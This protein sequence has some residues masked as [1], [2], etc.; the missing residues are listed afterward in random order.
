MRRWS[1]A[2]CPLLLAS[3]CALGGHAGRSRSVASDSAVT[4]PVVARAPIVQAAWPGD[5]V[6]AVKGSAVKLDAFE[7]LLVQAGVES[8]DQLPPRERPLDREGA[9]RLLALLVEKPLPLRSF[10]QRMG[11]CFLLREVLGSGP[12]SRDELNRR[13]DRFRQVAVLRP[14]GYL[15]WVLSGRT[16]QRAGQVEL[17]DGAF[18][19]DRFVLGQFY[20]GRRGAYRPVDA[21]L[22]PLWDSTILGEVYDDSDV[23]GRAMDG[24]E[25]AFFALA[26]AV[27]KFLS[28]PL[29]GIAELRNLPA[30]V[31]ALIASSPEYLE[32]FK[33]M[34]AGEQIQ[35]VSRLTTT[36]LT[37][38]AGGGAV[39]ASLTRGLGGMEVTGLALSTQGTLVLGRVVVP[40]GEVATVLAVGASVPIVLHSTAVQGQ[41][42][43]GNMPILL[44]EGGPKT[45]TRG[46]PDGA[47]TWGKPETL[48]DHFARHGADFGARTAQEYA[49]MASAFLRRSQAERLPTKIDAQGVIRVYDPKTNTFGAYNPGGTTRTF[50]KPGPATHGYPT[51]LDYW[52]AQPGGKP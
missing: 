29:D 3:G 27:G 15:A 28:R 23:F 42:S 1:A 50:Y 33:L 31:A 39:S 12:A 46:V 13:V 19:A 2:L 20:S 30:G 18:R 14:D 47:S 21:Q 22:Q 4:A 48:A 37:M 52:N 7:G 34:T 44:G 35:T 41:L 49:E 26:M 10:P 32:R 40:A 9:T 25:Q 45:P 16:Q 8:L 38:F 17:K 5:V 51:N 43:A 36:L 6:Q 11:A 24:T